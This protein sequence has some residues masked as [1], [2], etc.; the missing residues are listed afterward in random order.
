[1]YTVVMAIQAMCKNWDKVL[2]VVQSL[3][4]NILSLHKQ[5]TGHFKGIYLLYTVDW[6]GQWDSNRSGTLLV[7]ND[8]A[9]LDSGSLCWKQNYSG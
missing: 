8:T 3:I 2:D 7:L 1:M 5:Q 9:V 4:P 6:Q